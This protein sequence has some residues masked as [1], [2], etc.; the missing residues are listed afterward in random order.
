MTN[1]HKN[2]INKMDES[3]LRNTISIIS[4]G[5]NE[6]KAAIIEY[7]ESKLDGLNV[8]SALV[9]PADVSDAGIIND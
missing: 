6:H 3:Q 4:A 1:E 9:I 7:C 8:D 5:S 2:T